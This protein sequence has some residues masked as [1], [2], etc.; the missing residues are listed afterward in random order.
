MHWLLRVYWIEAS[1]ELKNH[2]RHARIE[3]A[4]FRFSD[5]QSDALPS[6]VMS[7]S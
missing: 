6:D 4:T 7:E 3:R 2:V 5:L 1:L